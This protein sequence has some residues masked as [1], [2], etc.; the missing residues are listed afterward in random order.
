[1]PLGY[2]VNFG[3]TTLI[4]GTNL[5]DVLTVSTSKGRQWQTD[6]YSPSSC[7]IT[8][9][10]ISAWTTAPKIGNL[11]GVKSSGT[12]SSW[13]FGGYIKDVQIVYGTIPALDVAYITCEG[14]LSKYGRRTFKS[15]SFAQADYETYITNVITA[16]GTTN[17]YAFWGSSGL[18]TAQTYTGNALD[19]VNLLTTSE[20]GF[21][22][23]NVLSNMPVA[24][25]QGR[26]RATTTPP[27]QG[28]FTDAIPGGT[29]TPR[30]ESVTFSSAAQ[31]YY[32]Q[33]TI[34]PQG[35]T[36]QQVESGS[37]P[38]IGIDQESLDYTNAQALAHAQYLL[39]KY[40]TTN[41]NIVALTATYAN[42]DTA[43]R[44]EYFNRALNLACGNLV[45]IQ[46][47]GTNYL[48]IVEGVS[49]LADPSNTQL[50]LTFSSFDNNNY[51]ILN[52]DDFGTLNYNKLGF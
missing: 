43:L 24:S 39:Y 32:T 8:S 19:L 33:V 3:G 7:T 47:R 41:S 14:P 42:Q 16:V 46:F 1:M 31:N 25:F 26:D 22:D 23:E 10:N 30:Y 11:I 45:S 6:P 36:T 50:E 49:V 5:N 51:L 48:G 37:A 35:L 12:G 52:D 34:N 15:R 28:G 44:Q 17:N 38:Y 40:D 9:R 21:I 27:T 2:T 4:N 29:K 20:L 18:Y 13:V